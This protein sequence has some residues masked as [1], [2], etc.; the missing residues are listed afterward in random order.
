MAE[1]NRN[2]KGFSYLMI[3]SAACA[4]IG[5]LLFLTKKETEEKIIMKD[6]LDDFVSGF[7]EKV[8]DR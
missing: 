7:S 1:N 4:V 2:Q 5:S 3:A 6:A 8:S